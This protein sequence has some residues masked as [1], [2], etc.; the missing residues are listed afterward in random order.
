MYLDSFNLLRGTFVMDGFEQSFLLVV[1]IVPTP[2]VWDLL[3]AWFAD[4]AFAHDLNG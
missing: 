1:S 3:K 2:F 4:L